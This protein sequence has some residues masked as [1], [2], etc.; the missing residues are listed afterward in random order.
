[1]VKT[2]DIRWKIAYTSAKLIDNDVKPT[3]FQLRIM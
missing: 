1:M 3:V 2:V